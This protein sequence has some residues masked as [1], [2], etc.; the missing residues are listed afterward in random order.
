ML[1]Q[2]MW[3]RYTQGTTT[4]RSTTVDYTKVEGWPFEAQYF[5]IVGTPSTITP[6]QVKAPYPSTYISVLAGYMVITQA[7]WNEDIKKLSTLEKNVWFM[8]S[9]VKTWFDNSLDE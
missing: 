3:T 1:A 4:T 2:I 5:N 8:E 6:L 9:R 7:M